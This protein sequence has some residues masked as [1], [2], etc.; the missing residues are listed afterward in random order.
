MSAPPDGDSGSGFFGWSLPELSRVLAAQFCTERD[1]PLDEENASAT[2]PVVD[3]IAL[4]L[5]D[6]NALC[7]AG[8]Q[9]H[10]EASP[11]S[12]Q[13]SRLFA[14]DD[15]TDGKRASRRGGNSNDWPDSGSEVWD[16]ETGGASQLLELSF[17]AQLFTD[18]DPH[19]GDKHRSS[20]STSQPVDPFLVPSEE[21]QDLHDL[22]DLQDLLEE[23]E[24][25]E[26]WPHVSSDAEARSE[27]KSGLLEPWRHGDGGSVSAILSTNAA[28]NAP[29]MMSEESTTTRLQEPQIGY[30]YMEI[31]AS[32]DVKK[33]G[34][35]INQSM[36]LPMVKELQPR[37]W[38]AKQGVLVGDEI[39]GLNGRPTDDLH[40]AEIAEVVQERPLNVRLRRPV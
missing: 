32:I 23:T 9:L 17:W 19:N 16:G 28:S 12:P 30:D 39:V 15:R 40:K 27:S 22:L 18:P 8:D 13:N 36:E 7:D 34:W 5:V 25:D 26:A 6:E 20:S 10:T 35:K 29:S 38:A 1:R 14:D 4:H 3:E 33:L 11:S 31:V 24:L 37:G 2:A 21:L